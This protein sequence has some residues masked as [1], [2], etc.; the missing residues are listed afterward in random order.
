MTTVCAT[1]DAGKSAR[2]TRNAPT[3]P[4]ADPAL[5]NCFILN[6]FERRIDP[7]VV[8]NNRD[9]GDTHSKQIKGD[10]AFLKLLNQANDRVSM[11]LLAFCLMPNHFHLV[12]WQDAAQC[13]LNVAPVDTKS[14]HS[15]YQSL[16]WL[17]WN[18]TS[19]CAFKQKKTPAFLLAISSQVL[20]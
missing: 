15:K 18:Q 2:R 11:R 8:V 19:T 20:V 16:G 13:P 5:I 3:D 9:E 12:A 1:A 4:D 6:S 17:D 7:Q 10:I 14:N